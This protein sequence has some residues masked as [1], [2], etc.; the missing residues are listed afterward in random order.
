MTDSAVNKIK[1]KYAY[2]LRFTNKGGSVM[3][4]IIQ[5]NFADGSSEIDRIHAYIWRLNEKEVT[6]TFMKSKKVTSILI[7]PYKETCDIDEKNNTWKMMPEPTKF[8]AFKT[9][10]NV[11]GQST[12]ENPMQKAKKK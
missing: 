9:K 3:P 6:K 12:G 5:W 1:D 2:E 10:A 7:D 4:I 8:E 11:R